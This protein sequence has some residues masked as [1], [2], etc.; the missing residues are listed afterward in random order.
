LTQAHIALRG[1]GW[2]LN[3]GAF[4]YSVFFQN[5]VTMFEETPGPEDAWVKETI[6]WLNEYIFVHPF[7]VV[8]CLF[9]LSVDRF[10]GSLT[11]LPEVPRRPRRTKVGFQIAS[12]TQL[13]VLLPNV[14]PRRLP[15][16]LLTLQ[17]PRLLMS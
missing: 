11:R 8:P 4:E 17:L 6:S 15:T 12:W 9:S 7:S 5:I 10:Q 1:S 3:D 2:V 13:R 16:N 14:L